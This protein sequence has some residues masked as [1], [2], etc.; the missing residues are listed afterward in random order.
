[1]DI[2]LEDFWMKEK[3]HLRSR[4]VEGGAPEKLLD[5]SVI[6]AANHARVLGEPFG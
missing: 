1:M 2:A 5:M 6:L 4:F 3:K